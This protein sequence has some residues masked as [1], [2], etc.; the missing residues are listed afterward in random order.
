MSDRREV[1][2]RDFR[3][4]GQACTCECFTPPSNPDAPYYCRECQHGFSKHPEALDPTRDAPRKQDGTTSGKKRLVSIFKEKTSSGSAARP[5]PS[6]ASSKSMLDQKILG[7]AQWLL[8]VNCLDT[9][10]RFSFSRMWTHDEVNQ[11]LQNEVFP[12]ALGYVNSTEKG[13]GIG[14]PSCP[15]VLI[16]KER[17][18]Y[19]VVNIERPDGNDLARFRGRPKCP[20]KDANIII[21]KKP[22]SYIIS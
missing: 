2:C 8:L 16:S 1:Y 18:R 15:W 4:G 13:K 17:L 3:Q 7:V 20:V 14:I 10:S 11:Y 19:E 21:G 12:L 5:L 9:A 6:A 22:L